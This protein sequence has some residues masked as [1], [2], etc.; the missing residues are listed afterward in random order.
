MVPWAQNCWN[1]GN[2]GWFS[3]LIILAVTSNWSH[4]NPS[5]SC[6]INIAAQYDRQMMSPRSLMVRAS[7]QEWSIW[8]HNCQSLSRLDCLFDLRARKL[9]LLLKSVKFSSWEV[10]TSSSLESIK[11]YFVIFYDFCHREKKHEKQ[12]CI[13]IYTYIYILYVCIY[14]YTIFVSGKNG[15]KDYSYHPPGNPIDSSASRRS[16]SAGITK[17][18]SLGTVERCELHPVVTIGNYETLVR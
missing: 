18:R 11:S 5:R 9:C 10:S 15:K 13:Y 3:L 1:K 8:Q 2:W 4:Y 6:H 7:K 16:G 14:I 17:Q 12:I